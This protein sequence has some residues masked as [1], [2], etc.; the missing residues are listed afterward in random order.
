MD[1][2]TVRIK[3]RKDLEDFN[4]K[5]QEEIGFHVEVAFAE[6]VYDK[7]EKKPA[8]EIGFAKKDLIPLLEYLEEFLWVEYDI[9]DPFDTI[10][11]EAQDEEVQK[12][13]N[14]HIASVSDRMVDRLFEELEKRMGKAENE[15]AEASEVQQKEGKKPVACRTE[16][17]FPVN[18][19]PEMTAYIKEL[20]QVAQALYSVGSLE[21]V[22][23]KTLLLSMDDGWGYSAFLRVI[24]QELAPFYSAIMK[25]IYVIEETISGENGVSAWEGV[26][27]RIKE[28][29]EKA[30]EEKKFLIV[31]YDM[32]EWMGQFSEPAFLNYLRRVGQ[33]A[34]NI[35]LVLRVPYMDMKTIRRMEQNLSNVL[36]IRSIVVPPVTSENMVVYLKDKLGASG[37]SVAE[38]CEDLLEQWICQEKNEGNFYGYKTLDK[39][40][41]ELIY[42]KALHGTGEITIICPT[43]VQPMLLEAA[44]VEDAYQLL[45][46]MIGMAQVKTR[47][48][49][50][51]AQIKMQKTMEEQGRAIDKPTMHMMFLGNPGTGKTTVARIIGQIFKQEGLLRKG[52]FIEKTGNDFIERYV[53][54]TILKV[55]TTC[56]DAYGSVLFIDEA[57][58][59]D[60]GT[61]S[62]STAEEIVPILVAEME[63][64]REDMCVILAGYKEEMKEFLR[65]NAGLE[66]R[67][68]HVIEFP[69]YTRAE[70]V[71]IFFNL[72]EGNFA[73]EDALKE[74]ITEYI[75]NIPEEVFHTR[76]F[77]NGRFVRNLY[78]HL[79]GKAAYRIS[80]SGESEI[81]LK[82][83][84]MVSVMEEED[85]SEMVAEKVTKRIGFSV[86]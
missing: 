5:L 37:F 11:I 46:E 47:V 45:N 86:V 13:V 14:E 12:A 69:N 84:D 27:K 81:I 48:R 55:R 73:Y 78:E 9:V 44:C 21:Q 52:H 64:H 70:L 65:S 6:P 33:Y 3:L 2:V 59:M 24:Q 62:G 85:F 38:G 16:F 36:S 72:V 63:N 25:S 60:V 10:E 42:H 1:D 75:N 49:E 50:I 54:T 26:P 67:I 83:E 40:A 80:L 23:A 18:F 74:T 8:L 28:L 53:G 30:T 61:S 58:G 66:S 15:N 7:S 76:E 43:D 35:L 77:S 57:Y 34:K 71:Q 68:P 39:M 20:R 79:W 22:Y 31:A 4:S 19:S 51:V 41:G 82:K 32:R 56:R 17:A 29:S